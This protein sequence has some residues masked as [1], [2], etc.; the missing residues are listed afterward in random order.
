[1]V[2]IKLLYLAD[3]QSL[4]QMGH[5]ITGDWMV[6]MP[7]GP[8]LSRVYD[9]VNMGKPEEPTAWFEYISEPRN[10]DV[11]CIKDAPETD[12]LSRYE[13]GV[14]DSV[15]EKYGR[16]DKF[17]LRDLTHTLPEWRDP[18]GSSL[19]IAPED[20][21]RAADKSDADIQRIAR[22]AEE[23]WFM[24]QLEHGVL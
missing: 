22:D 24:N 19:S 8:V 4:V 18:K 7:H 15:H 17:A 21:L 13:I 3:R 23:L 1:M 11:S 12:E 5:P 9:F 20:I 16:M 10:Y 14:L 6:S 2:L